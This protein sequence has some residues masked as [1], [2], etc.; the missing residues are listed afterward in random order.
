MKRNIGATRF[1]IGGVS[2]SK[3]NKFIGGTSD[4]ISFMFSA[5]LN[6]TLPSDVNGV[7]EDNRITCT[8]PNNADVGA[9]VAE[10]T[11]NGVEVEID[12]VAQ[13]NG[14][15]V[16]DFTFPVTYRVYAEDG[17]YKDYGVA[18]DRAPATDKRILSFSVAG[19]E[20]TIDESSHAIQVTLPAGSDVHAAMA[21]FSITGVSVTVDGVEQ[22][23]GTTANDFSAPLVYRV[24]AEDGSTQDYTVTVDVALCEDK[25]ITAFKFRASDNGGLADD[26]P[27]IIA[28]DSIQLVLP[29]G[30]SSMTL[31][32][33]FETTGVSVTV[34]GAV[35]VSGAP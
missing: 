24:T 5:R 14:E 11:T 13:V 2:T 29:C 25:E 16:N 32:A 21:S 35:Q 15:S 34:E 20:G 17:S 6:N 26:V 3:G 19:V 27:G 23:S 7:I 10:Y 12:G 28:G 30:S 31:A 9:L 22:E 1:V 4:I 18:V 33:Y 8:V